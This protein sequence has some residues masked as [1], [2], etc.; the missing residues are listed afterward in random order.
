MNWYLEVLKKYAVFSGRA[1]R[2]EY[3]MFTLVN[4]V[5]TILLMIIDGA[6]GLGDRGGMGPLRAVYTLAVLIPG[7]AVSVRRLHDV[8]RSGWWLFIALIP[9]VGG[10]ILLVFMVQ[11]G[12]PEPNEYGPNPKADPAWPTYGSYS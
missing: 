2:R 7:I 4:F 1:R 3:W 8:G 10:I 11:D 12:Q 9:C 6:L 5:I